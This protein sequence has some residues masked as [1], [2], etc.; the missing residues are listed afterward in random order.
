MAPNIRNR[1]YTIAVEVTI[2]TEEAGGVLF[3]QGARF[4]G[5]ALYIKDRKLKY[6]YNLVR[7]RRSR[8]SSPPSPSR[9]GHVVVSRRPS[10]GRGDTMPAEGTL[11]LH[12]GEEKVGEGRIRTQPGKFSLAARA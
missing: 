4:G 2:D 5:H 10:S 6:V 12:I 1:S 11:T 3:A 8:S 9:L 7:A